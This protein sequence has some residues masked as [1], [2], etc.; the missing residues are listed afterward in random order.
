MT[1]KQSPEYEKL[2][3]S[4]TSPQLA[5]E[6]EIRSSMKMSRLRLPRL[7]VTS[8]NSAANC[9]GIDLRE[10]VALRCLM[11]TPAAWPDSSDAF[12]PARRYKDRGEACQADKFVLYAI[13]RLRDRRELLLR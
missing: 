12:K 2:T 4:S 9:R 6:Q 13:R 5:G 1:T 7:L 3:A 10:I 8:L 11:L